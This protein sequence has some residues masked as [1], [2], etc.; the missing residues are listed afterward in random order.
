MSTQFQPE[1]PFMSL[2]SE[3]LPQDVIRDLILSCRFNSDMPEGHVRE[4][5]RGEAAMQVPWRARIARGRL[6]KRRK[7]QNARRGQNLIQPTAGHRTLRGAGPGGRTV[8]SDAV[9]AGGRLP[10]E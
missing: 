7:E 6:V 9:A 8:R 10:L 2:T 5:T 4:A 3:G 1:P